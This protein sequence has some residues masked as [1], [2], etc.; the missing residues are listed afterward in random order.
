MAITGDPNL[1]LALGLFL[2]W[3]SIPAMV[4]AYSDSRPPRVSAVV[5]VTGGLLVLWAF[6]VKPGG[7]SLSEIPLAIYDVLGRIRFF[8]H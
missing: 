5:V 3:L 4:S 1:L 2:A 7:Y 8:G 6:Q